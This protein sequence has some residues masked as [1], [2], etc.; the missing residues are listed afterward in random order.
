MVTLKDDIMTV[1][2]I[3]EQTYE[4]DDDMMGHVLIS[5]RKFGEINK[6]NLNEARK[7]LYKM[8]RDNQSRINDVND[9]W[10]AMYE[11]N[12]KSFSSKFIG[13]ATGEDVS[14]LWYSNYTDGYLYKN[15]TVGQKDKEGA[16]W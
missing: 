3:M 2:R 8:V 15:G 9:H 1:Y 11:D 13:M 16:I 10:L 12:K 5:K 7:V 6:P 14:V 4:I